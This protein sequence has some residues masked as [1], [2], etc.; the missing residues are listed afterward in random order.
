MLNLKEFDSLPDCALAPVTV[1]RLLAGIAPSTAWRRARTDPTFPKPVRLGNRCTR[2]RVG[3]IRAFL[4]GSLPAPAA[5]AEPKPTNRARLAK[6][7]N[8]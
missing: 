8:V 1:F 5:P 6:G 7:R 4:A 3:D 2:F